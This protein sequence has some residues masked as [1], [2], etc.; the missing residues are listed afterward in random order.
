MEVPSKEGGELIGL[1]EAQ[2]KGDFFYAHGSGAEQMA[3]LGENIAHAGRLGGEAGT[4]FDDRV[5]VVGMH[6]EGPGIESDGALGIVVVADEF[7]EAMDK[8]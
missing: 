1:I 3:G 5:E 4:P 7:I 2:L 6:V 8:V